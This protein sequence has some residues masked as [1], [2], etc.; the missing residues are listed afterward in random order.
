[1]MLEIKLPLIR[2]GSGRDW[3]A[4]NVMKKIDFKSGHLD[5][6]KTFL[7]QLSFFAISLL[8]F[9]AAAAQAQARKKKDKSGRELIAVESHGRRLGSTSGE[10]KK[11]VIERPKRFES[12]H[13]LTEC[14]NETCLVRAGIQQRSSLLQG[15]AGGP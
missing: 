7:G 2:P 12:S 5:A 1:M 4:G 14:I 13:P 10:G 15:R 11:E 3:H 6:P 9:R 8:C